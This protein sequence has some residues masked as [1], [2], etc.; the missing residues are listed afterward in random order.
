MKCASSV[1]VFMGKVQYF[2]NQFQISPCQ[3]EFHLNL[4]LLSSMGNVS[5]HLIKCKTFNQLQRF[6][7]FPQVYGNAFSYLPFTAL[8]DQKPAF[9]FYKEN[10][11]WRA[12]NNRMPHAVRI[13]FYLPNGSTTPSYV[14]PRGFLGGSG[15]VSAN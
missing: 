1:C 15:G 13:F 11:C 9:C 3:N 14:C 12:K 7:P 6:P 4:Y 10:A 5:K 2:I 8:P